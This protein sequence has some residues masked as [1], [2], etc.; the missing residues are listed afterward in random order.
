MSQ[1][2]F[3][4]ARQFSLLTVVALSVTATLAL[5]D[6]RDKAKTNSILAQQAELL[7]IQQKLSQIE[8]ELLTA[9]LQEES[10]IIRQH[11]LSAFK[12]FNQHLQTITYL[13]RHLIKTSQQPTIAD[14]TVILLRTLGR[15]EKSVRLTL[16]IQQRMGLTGA[17]LLGELTTLQAQIQTSL[18]MTNDPQLMLRFT[19]LQLYT[20]DFSTSL[21]MKQ[22][23]RLLS[24]TTALQESVL[25]RTLPPEKQQDL[26]ADMARYYDLLEQLIS[27]TVELELTVAESELQFE[28]IQPGLAQNQRIVNQLLETTSERLIQQQ[29]LSKRQAIAIFSLAFLVLLGFV[30]YQ[31]QSAQQLISRLQQ[32]A[33]GMR[34]VATGQLVKHS[35][36]PQG[37]DEIGRLTSTFLEMAAQIQVQIETNKQAQ[38]KAEIA[39]QSKSRFLAHMSHELR[40]PLNAI[41]GFTQL[42]SQDVSLNS[43]QRS[44]LDII[45]TS[46]GYLLD[47]INDVLDMAKIEAGKASLEV[48]SFNLF[49]LLETLEKMLQIKAAA[50]GLEM[51]LVRSPNLPRQVSTDQRKL[52]QILLNLL[53]NAVKFTEQGQIT[54]R[55]WA[56]VI[57]AD[58]SS[59]QQKLW[60][61][62]TDTGPGIAPQDISSLFDAFKQGQH[63][64]QA[65]G[66][67]LGLTICKSFVELMS[68][69][70]SVRSRLGEGTTFCFCI[71]AEPTA[72]CPDAQVNPVAIHLAPQQ[73]PYRILV[74]ED[75]RLSRLLLAK[76]LK[77]V[78]LQPREV[79]DGQAAV[80]VWQDWQ[81]HLIWMDMRMPI[82]DGYEATR[83]I[84]RKEREA[85]TARPGT[86]I[87]ALTAS[88]FISSQQDILAAG[89]DDVLHKPLKR[90]LILEKM[91][92]HLG[93][94]Y[95][96][97][98]SSLRLTPPPAAASPAVLKAELLKD[99]SV[100]WIEQLHQ[101][102]RLADSA[103]I[104][105][106]IEQIPHSCQV[107]RAALAALDAQFAYEAILETTQV[108]TSRF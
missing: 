53:G 6:F 12:P 108:L 4:L 92:E 100:Q 71:Q 69:K 18:V 65:E 39:N 95:L 41:L 63:G 82:M 44:Q 37:Y 91:S 3:K 54:L 40:T 72:F 68:G 64:R 23:D 62:V 60:F 49:E 1:K 48:S 66:T 88:A 98:N 24:Q 99:M 2:R 93:I 7:D 58:G 9:R 70:I 81:P 57:A 17:G 84:R 87:I 61:E 38:I 89:C 59:R 42:M 28:R 5:V 45:N 35:K 55:A 80:D 79:T 77:D 43:E 8:R 13:A 52:R 14:N 76:L 73:Q 94:R 15:Y 51:I 104:S 29:Q 27:S 16:K 96:Y 26:L 36:L 25:Q 105:S 32:L 21:D 20:Q 47:L 103:A 86:K 34:E 107:L 78:G 75:D 90:R 46:G 74:V 30:I 102:A 10:G 50:A 83:Q 22:A 67:G 11:Q 85:Q 33:E 101:A 19:Q 97:Q 106:L 56:E 31:V